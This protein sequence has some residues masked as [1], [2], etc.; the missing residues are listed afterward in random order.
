MTT[1][2]PAAIAK[3]H[4]Q[5]RDIV[6][7]TPASGL[8]YVNFSAH[9]LAA[10][11]S[12]AARE[13]DRESCIVVLTGTVDVRAGDENWRGIGERQSVFEEKSPYAVYVPPGIE[14]QV[15]AR[16]PSEIAIGRA[17]AAGKLGPRLIQPATMKRLARGRDA[18]TRYVCDILPETEPAE[19]L[20][21]V[22]VLTPSGHSSSYPPHKHDTDALPG[23][24]FL[25]ETY[26]HRIDPA[27]GFVF[28]RVY[29]D[30]RSEDRSFAVE[31]GDVVIVPR[32]Y[33][34]VCVPYGYRSYYLNVMA[35]PKRVWSFR[36]D[37]RHEW[38]LAR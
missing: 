17:P 4:P 9:R 27:Q 34:P 11:E 8:R 10:G 33:H 25:E 7:V 28:Q 23:E 32:G 31:D 29:T 18:N 14:Y 38:M 13:A 15:A 26:Y 2:A 20:L 37:P 16:T 22:E 1:V 6:E 12:L 35:G 36:N 3:A 21:V 5:G 30:D 24:S 19:S